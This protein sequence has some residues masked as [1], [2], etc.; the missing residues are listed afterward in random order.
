MD[1]GFGSG[2]RA[3]EQALEKTKANINWV[4]ENKEVVLNWFK[5]HSLTVSG[6]Y[7]HLVPM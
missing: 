7:I 6:P 3:L 4:K 2:T 5:E 1:V